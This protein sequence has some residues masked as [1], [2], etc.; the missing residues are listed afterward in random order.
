MRIFHCNDVY[1][2]RTRDCVPPPVPRG[3]DFRK[4]EEEEFRGQDEALPGDVLGRQMDRLKRFGASYCYGAY[5]DGRLASFA[6][7]LPAEAVFRDVPHVLRLRPGEC[8]LT[9]TETLPRFRGR[10]LYTFVA[11]STFAVA[12]EMGHHHVY[13]KMRRRAQ[14]LRGYARLGAEFVGTVR[15]VWLPGTPSALLA[16]PRAFQ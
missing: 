3:V 14:P 5:V 15:Y 1:R 10:W 13:F 4:V 2:R 12:R 9:A 16:W 7:L 11:A 8:E 6:W